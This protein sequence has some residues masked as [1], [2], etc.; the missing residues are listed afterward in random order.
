MSEDLS[1]VI[2]QYYNIENILES[3]ESNKSIS[4]KEDNKNLQ[5]FIKNKLSLKFFEK[6]KNNNFKTYCYNFKDRE[7]F[8]SHSKIDCSFTIS[9]YEKKNIYSNLIYLS[10]MSILLKEILKKH[11]D[12]ITKINNTDKYFDFFK[13]NKYIEQDSVFKKCAEEINSPYIVNKDLGTIKYP[14]IRLKKYKIII[15]YENQ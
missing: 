11:V 12:F 5:D 1:N 7:T 14:Q 15:C 13:N 2:S 10:N 9:H 3:I 8:L 6:Q 4:K